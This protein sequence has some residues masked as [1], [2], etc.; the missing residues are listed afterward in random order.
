MKNLVALVLMSLLISCVNR[1]VTKE[2][3][4]IFSSMV[5][6][7]EV[8]LLSDGQGEGNVEI[9]IG[10]TAAMLEE[11]V[12]SGNFPMGFNAFLVKTP[13]KNILVDTGNGSKLFANLTAI[14]VN[15]S[16]IDA[17][18]ITHMHFDHIGGLLAN[19]EAMFPNAELYI[20]QS[21]HDYWTSGEGEGFDLARTVV[22]AYKDK[23]SL[24]ETASLGGEVKELIPSVIAISAPGHTP[25]HIMYM[26]S[27]NG[28]Q[29][30]IWGDLAHAMAI[31]MPYPQVA[32]TY[33]INPEQ[34][35]K[36]RKKVMEYV[37]EN[38]IP[39]AGMHIP[40]PAMGKI[41]SDG[42]GYLFEKFNP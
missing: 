2:T 32:V 29:M 33:D 15:P 11:Y 14:N 40:F 27:S 8:I 22:E 17:I 36:D 5:G 4:N 6:D 18:L 3:G 21:E 34:A 28:N 9:L 12:P 39:V 25:G 19:G 1:S 20:A 38:N 30:L 35:I 7:C 26:V 10:A 16:E 31:Q 41:E 37:S 13:E 24:F 23:L 42:E